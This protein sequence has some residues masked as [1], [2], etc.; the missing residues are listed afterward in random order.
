MA[1]RMMK[2]AG[3]VAAGTIVLDAKPL[4]FSAL[5]YRGCGSSSVTTSSTSPRRLEVCEAARLRVESRMTSCKPTSH[6]R[7]R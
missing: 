1:A 6:D 3:F 5:P 7:T 4:R 2:V